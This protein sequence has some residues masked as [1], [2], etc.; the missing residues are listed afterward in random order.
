M[1]GA[2][3]LFGPIFEMRMTNGLGLS[4][5]KQSTMKKDRQKI[6]Y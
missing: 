2:A 5:Q 1:I 4:F 6:E 3:S